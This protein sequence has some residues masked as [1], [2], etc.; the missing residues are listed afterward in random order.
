MLQS[1]GLGNPVQ[2]GNC[3]RKA[4]VSKMSGASKASLLGER[5]QIA[6]ERALSEFR[7]GRPVLISSA[8]EAVTALPVDGMTEATLVAFRL[9][10]RP[11]RPF[12]LVTAPRARALG[13]EAAVLEETPETPKLQPRLTQERFGAAS[14]LFTVVDPAPVA[15]WPR[16]VRAAAHPADAFRAVSLAPDPVAD[17]VTDRPVPHVPGAKVRLVSDEPDRCEVEVSGDFACALAMRH[18]SLRP[19]PHAD[20]RLRPLARRRATTLRPPVVAIRLRKPC[21]RLRTSLLGW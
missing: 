3:R 9:L 13:V 1:L 16:S 10:S 20:R 4:N 12:L 15:S 7:S 17:A 11:V 18:P 6:V 19:A 5:A 8:G 14:H 2:R 21:R